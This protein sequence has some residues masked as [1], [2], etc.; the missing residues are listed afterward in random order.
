MNTFKKLATLS[1]ALT[2]ILSLGALTACGG[3]DSVASSSSN[4]ASSVSS[5][6]ESTENNSSS[7]ES[8]VYENYEFIVLDKDGNKVDGYK[9][10][11][12]TADG[13]NCYNPVD[14]VNGECVYNAIPN[15]TLGEYAVHVLDAS[16]QEVELKEAVTTSATAYGL[17]T[18][19]LAE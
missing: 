14:A 4:T 1:L 15:N 10:Q 11:L 7:E 13:A 9:V 6:V 19:Q 8:K 2:F 17:Y 5:P 3:D 16:Y 18:L 12:C